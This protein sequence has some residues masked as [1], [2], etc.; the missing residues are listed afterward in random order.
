MA[1]EDVAIDETDRLIASNKVEGTA[2]YNRQGERLGTIYNFMVDKRSGKVE[3]AVL[4]FGG[5]LGIGTENF[6]LPWDV[7]DYDPDQRGYVVDIDKEVLEK[8]P[9]YREGE[10]P[11]YD[12]DYGREVYSYY[13]I[14]YPY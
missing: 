11:R 5:F 7:L 10:E 4:Q 1:H 6:P 2:V 12:R 3:Y 13:N 14:N 9:R 8:A